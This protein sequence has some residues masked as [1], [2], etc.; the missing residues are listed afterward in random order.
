MTTLLGIIFGFLSPILSEGVKIYQDKQ[1]K[2]HEVEL[3]KLQMQQQVQG[4]T[5]KLE[6][7]EAHADIEESKEIY[8]TYSTQ[9]KWVDA[10]N[11]TVRPII[12]YSFFILYAVVKF[13][14]YQA[15]INW[16]LWTEEDA[17]IFSTIIA[18][19]FG[20]RTMSKLR[21]K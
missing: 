12:A 6:E 2:K 1:D 18:F 11:G 5:A 13:L 20:N 7:I 15:N 17:L 10:L 19:Y 21:G 14:Q 3:L 16:A 8:K 9:I 4:Y